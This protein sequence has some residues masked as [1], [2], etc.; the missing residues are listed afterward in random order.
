ML[1]A[2]LLVIV[3]VVQ[4]GSTPASKPAPPTWPKLEGK[5]TKDL[6]LAIE[7]LKRAP[8]AEGVDAALDKIRGFGKPAVPYLYEALSRQ[9]VEADGELSQEATRLLGALDAVV[10]RE[11]GARLAVDTAHRHALVRRFA[12]RKCGEFGVEAALAAAKKALA[13]PDPD[14][15][16]EAALTGAALGSLDGFEVLRRAAR[17]DWPARGARLRAILERHRSEAATEKC[18]PGLASSDWQDVCASLRLL[19]GWGVRSCA[20]EVARHLDTTDNRVK[21]S[22]INALRGIVD[23]EPPIEKLSAFDLAEQAIAWKKRL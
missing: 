12:L 1:V 11:D 6:G 3:A 22:C 17:D 14:T 15:R 5:S 7:S 13:D 21:E 16:F 2:P 18:L 9:K 19:A 4:G 20:S 23:G 10:D 8:T